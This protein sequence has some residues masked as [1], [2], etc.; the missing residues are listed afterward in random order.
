[1][2]HAA[3]L[4]KMLRHKRVMRT[5]LLR[6]RLQKLQGAKIQR[7]PQVKKQ[8]KPIPFPTK[9]YE[10]RINYYLGKDFIKK[11]PVNIHKRPNSQT[12]MKLSKSKNKTGPW[13]N[14]AGSLLRLL[15]KTNKKSQSFNLFIGD[16]WSPQPAGTLLKSRNN[17]DSSSLLLRC[18][19]FNRHWDNYYRRPS[20]IPF[21]KKISGA[22]WR[23]TTTGRLSGASRFTLVK[24]WFNKNPKINVGFSHICQNRDAYNKYVKGSQPMCNMLRY[25]YILSVEGND[26]DSGINWKLNSNSLVFMAKPRVSSWLMESTLIPNYHYILLKDNFSDLLEKVRW[27]DNNPNKCKEIIKNANRFMSQFKNQRVEEN[28]EKTVINKYFELTGQLFKRR[29]F[30][31]PKNVRDSDYETSV[32]EESVIEESVIEESVIEESVE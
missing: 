5:W 13:K 27:C 7:Q 11:P 32:I 10:K 2:F 9:K 25:K 12:F 15:K 6:R 24:T 22:I 16:N 4:I 14:Y 3:N 31:L 28:I 8:A 19:D 26:K 17:N 18:L 29:G 21:D 20:D 23:G 30:T 1:M